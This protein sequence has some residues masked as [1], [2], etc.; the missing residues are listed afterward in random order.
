MQ[1]KSEYLDLRLCDNMQLMA[2]YPDGY[3]ELAI[4]DPPYGIDM[5]QQM[6]K[7]GQTCQNN[8]Y[9][10]HKNKNWDTVTPQ[11]CYFDELMRVS[12]NQIIW[13]GKLFY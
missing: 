2:Q 12:K 11:K 6:Y 4:C 10:E 13:G 7:R 3:F 1:H 8:G 9:K 5:S